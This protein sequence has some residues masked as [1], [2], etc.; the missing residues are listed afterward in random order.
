MAATST[1]PGE[2]PASPNVLDG[3]ARLPADVL[4]GVAGA[5]DGAR[6]AQPG[7]AAVRAAGQAGRLTSLG[8]VGCAVA[9]LADE[10]L[11]LAARVAQA[12]PTLVRVGSGL[13]RFAPVAGLVVSGIDV[14]RAVLEQDPA[15]KTRATGLAVL[16]VTSGVAGVVGAVAVGLAVP[17]LAAGAAVVGIGAAAAA[18]LD[19]LVLGGAVSR[20]VGKLWQRL[21][22]AGG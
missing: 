16:S 15:K 20:P 10:A 2:R 22:G 14:G 8:A 11:T 21:T 9:S 3:K 5:A 4:A 7:I 6:S 17:P 12:A 13:A 1:A 19:Q 18:A